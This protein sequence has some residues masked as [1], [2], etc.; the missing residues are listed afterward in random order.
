M[1]RAATSFLLTYVVVSALL[2]GL[3]FLQ[4]FPYRPTTTAGWALLFGLALPITVV[5]EMLGAWLLSNRLARTVNE[6]TSAKPVSWLRI[7]YVVAAYLVA[8]A[9][10]GIGYMFWKRLETWS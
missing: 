4:L 1:L 8:F 9:L 7:A 3:S 5:G 2:A 6:S 10:V